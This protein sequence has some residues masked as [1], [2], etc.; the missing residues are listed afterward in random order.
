MSLDWKRG[1]K[2]NYKKPYREILRD[3]KKRK[4]LL[5]KRFEKAARKK[6]ENRPTTIRIGMMP[7]PISKAPLGKVYKRADSVARYMSGRLISIYN[8][9]FYVNY[10]TNS[11]SYG[12]KYGEFA[13]TKQWKGIYIH[14]K[15]KKKKGRDK[16]QKGR[17]GDN[18]AGSGGVSTKGQ[19]KTQIIKKG[20]KVPKHTIKAKAKA[21]AKAKVKAKAITKTKKGNK[22]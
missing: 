15:K 8:G 4:R 18:K 17:H 20:Q 22:K 12:H 19:K 16:D 6:V 5:M 13:Y 10:R 1:K 14:R 11:A 9:R 7:F 3:K 2:K 21:K